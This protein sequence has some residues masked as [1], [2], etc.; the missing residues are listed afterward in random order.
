VN[1]FVDGSKVVERILWQG[2]A[3]LLYVVPVWI[4]AEYLKVMDFDEKF[5][6]ERQVCD[7]RHAKLNDSVNVELFARRA[8][9]IRQSRERAIQL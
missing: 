1:R 2:A 4:S 8:W 7:S 3:K 6:P 9:L 5:E